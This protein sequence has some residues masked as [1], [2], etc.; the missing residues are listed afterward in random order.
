[1]V[2]LCLLLIVVIYAS[3][4]KVKESRYRPSVAKRVQ[5]G[6]GSQIS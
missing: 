1:M 3:Y 6:L 2:F 5:G 4:K